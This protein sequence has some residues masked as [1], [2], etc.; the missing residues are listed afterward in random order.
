MQEVAHI[1]RH[2][3]Q[4]SL[5]ILDEVGRGTSTFDGISLARAVLEKLAGLRARTLFA[6]HYHELIALAETY[7]HIANFSTTVLDREGEIV[8]THKV[9]PGGSDRSYGIEVA[10]LAGLPASVLTRAAAL[11][12]EI[13]ADRLEP[14][15]VD[16]Q[17]LDA[18][19]G[20]GA[21]GRSSRR[22]RP[23]PV[24]TEQ[25]TF[26][27]EAR[28]APSRVRE[29][30]RDLDVQRLTPLEALNLLAELQAEARREEQ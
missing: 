15:L 1:L 23:R 20:A 9:R 17:R 30:L 29:R 28:P 3:T 2:A 7:E 11:L 25:F 4:R 27:P 6:T 16:G 21:G 14:S 18:T 13:E 12:Q 24:A 10:R 19:G 5:V 26:L 22:A 8:F